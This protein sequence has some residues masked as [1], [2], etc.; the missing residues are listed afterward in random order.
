VHSAATKPFRSAREVALSRTLGPPSLYTGARD[1]SC[2]VDPLQWTPP[3]TWE[4]APEEGVLM[5][6]PSKYSLEFREQAVEL[7][8]GLCR[9]ITPV[10]DR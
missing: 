2:G 7:V 10:G 4:I 9:T 6:R 8:R 1:L 5:G 3:R